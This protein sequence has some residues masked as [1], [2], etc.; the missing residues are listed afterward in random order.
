MHRFFFQMIFVAKTLQKPVLFQLLKIRDGFPVR[1][2]PLQI[3]A[4][5]NVSIVRKKIADE[6]RCFKNALRLRIF[7]T[8]GKIRRGRGRILFILFCE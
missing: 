6:L 4:F 3:P 2:A 7:R 5:C 1:L 8:A